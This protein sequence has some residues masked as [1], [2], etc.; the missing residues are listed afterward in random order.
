LIQRFVLNI[1]QKAYPQ[2]RIVC[3]APT[4]RAARR[5]EQS[6]GYPAAT[7]HRT[8]GLTYSD[9]EFEVY[10]EPAEIEAEFI[11]VDEASMLD[12]HMASL[13][14]GALKYGAQIVFI[15]D[16]DQLPSVG[17]GAVLGELIGCAAVPVVMLDKVYRQVAGSRVAVNAQ[18]IRHGNTALEYGD[19]FVFI[20]SSSCQHAAALLETIYLQ[21]TAQCGLDYVALLSPFRKRTATGVNALNEQLRA[22]LNPPA[23]HKSEI[24][25]GSRLF[26]WGDKV[27]QT[28]NV[29]D[30]SNGDIGYIVMADPQAGEICLRVDFG[31]GRI[32]EYEKAAL[33]QLELAYA[34]TVHKSQGSEYTTVLINL[35]NEHRHMLK[36][37][38]VYTAITRA[39]ERVVIVGEQKALR[40]AISTIDTEQRN[41]MLARRIIE[42]V[43]PSGGKAP[44]PVPKHGPK[45]LNS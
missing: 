40:T 11:L 38:L 21:E 17:P 43:S 9:D 41:T 3:C 15:G 5:M 35:Q 18:L 12:I 10:H 23:A 2:A 7:V 32:V 31:D 8:L 36:R 4:G 45:Q 39:K 19:D 1:Y 28:K 26:R 14:L 25:H 33:D 27:M 24:A 20:E 34:S 42:A 16:A 44:S 29:E 30:I 6:T 13:L 22:Q 37:P